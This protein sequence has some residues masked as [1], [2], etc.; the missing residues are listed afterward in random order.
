MDRAGRRRTGY[1]A[2]VLAAAALLVTGGVLAYVGYAQTAGPAGAV[3]GYFAALARSDAPGALAFGDVPDGPRALLTTSVLREQQRIAPLRRFAVL[4]TRRQG[5]EGSV[6]VGYILAFAGHPV[7][8]RTTVPVHDSSSGWRLDQT[9][10]PTELDANGARERASILG[11]RLPTGQTLL[12]PGALPVRLDTPYLR[13]DPAKDAVSFG[14]LPT[15]ELHVEVSDAGRAAMA[16]AVRGKL[17]TCL[18]RAGQYACPLPAQ[19]YVPGSVR[20]RIAGGMATPTVGLDPIDPAGRI[21]FDAAVT[22]SGS[23]Q[24][25]DFHNRPSAGRGQFTIDVGAAAYAAAPLTVTWTSS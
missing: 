12:F 11:A 15:T 13:V 6:E 1:W 3:R 10:V 14:A 7:P 17:V 4:S 25:L 23:Y 2:C 21:T 22:V 5:S 18:S 24:R 9:S 8:V 20:G 19:S 16:A